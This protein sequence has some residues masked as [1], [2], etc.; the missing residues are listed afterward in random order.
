MSQPGYRRS[1]LRPL[2]AKHPLIC[3]DEPNYFGDLYH[4]GRRA[5]CNAALLD[6][7]LLESDPAASATISAWKKAEMD[8]LALVHRLIA[9]NISKGAVHV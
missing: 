1:V 3:T 8:I 7:E 4:E 6:I 9:I 5:L 2:A